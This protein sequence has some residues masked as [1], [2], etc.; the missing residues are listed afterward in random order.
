[1]TMEQKIIQKLEAAFQP[2]SLNVINESHLHAGHAGDD[3]SGQSHFKVEI[4]AGA[5]AG[6]ATVARQRAVYKALA[7]EMAFIHALSIQF[8]DS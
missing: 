8:T 7:E 1:M 2:E 5:F 4:S 3:G 6:M